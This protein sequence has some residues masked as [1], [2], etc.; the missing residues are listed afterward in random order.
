MFTIITHFIVLSLKMREIQNEEKSLQDSNL[1]EDKLAI[2]A[3]E[4][5]KSLN[6]TIISQLFKGQE[7]STLKCLYCG[8][9]STKFGTFTCLS[10]S[11][12]TSNKCTLYVSHFN[13]F[14]TISYTLHRR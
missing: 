14:S 11:L 3:W 7:K 10:L 8:K 13:V 12:P 4:I 1:P 9:T 2:K 5:Q 6:N